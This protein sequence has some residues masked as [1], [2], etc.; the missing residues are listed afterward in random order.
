MIY[1][2]KQHIESKNDKNDVGNEDQGACI[3]DN[4]VTKL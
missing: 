2:I 3:D 4:A 1:E